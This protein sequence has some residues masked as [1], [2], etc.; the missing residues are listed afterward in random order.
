MEYMDLTSDQIEKIL[1]KKG[2]D[3]QDQ[4]KHEYSERDTQVEH[5]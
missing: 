5:E 4:G 3:A 2:G 1:G